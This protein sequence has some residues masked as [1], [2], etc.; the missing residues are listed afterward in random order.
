MAANFTKTLLFFMLFFVFPECPSNS[1]PIY[2]F[3]QVCVLHL[4]RDPFEVIVSG[5][6]YHRRGAERCDLTLNLPLDVA[7]AR[8]SQ[9]MKI[10][11]AVN[12]H[13]L[14]YCRLYSIYFC[15]QYFVSLAGGQ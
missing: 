12:P 11:Y 15:L 13:T 9:F 3:G 2:L 4:T 5:M 10:L 6:L 14:P 1:V 7:V 8:A